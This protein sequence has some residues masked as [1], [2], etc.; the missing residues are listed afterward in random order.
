[1]GKKSLWEVRKVKKTTKIVSAL[2]VLVL[3][4]AQIV[5]V[6]AAGTPSFS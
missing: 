1:M 6:N 3:M 4:M 5:C 2:L